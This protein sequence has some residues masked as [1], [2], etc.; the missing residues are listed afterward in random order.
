MFLLL[1]FDG[2]GRE[3]CRRALVSGW[4]REP[5]FIRL[6]S[7]KEKKE[8]ARREKDRGSLKD[9]SGEKKVIN[10]R[11]LPFKTWGTLSQDSWAETLADNLCLESFLLFITL[12][13]LMH[14]IISSQLTQNSPNF[15][16]FSHQSSAWV[17][18]GTRCY[19]QRG[20]VDLG[21]GSLQRRSEKHQTCWRSLE[22]MVSPGNY[23]RGRSHG[24]HTEDTSRTVRGCWWSNAA[25]ESLSSPV[26]SQTAL[27]L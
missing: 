25:S 24:K 15:V 18:T 26:R 3:E 16:T 9:Y 20:L 23:G 11:L 2:C 4:R 8:C 13:F 1:R 22:D 12:P 5:W 6:Q 14:L 27:K 10:K 17:G 19:C 7:N 21:P